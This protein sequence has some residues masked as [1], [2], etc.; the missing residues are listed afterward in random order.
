MRAPSAQ[1]NQA[2]TVVPPTSASCSSRLAKLGPLQDNG[3]ATQTHALLS[4]SPAIDAGDNTACPG[5]DQR[6]VV[7]PVDGNSDRVAICEIGAVEAA[8][9]TTVPTPAVTPD[10]TPAPTLGG[11]PAVLPRTGGPPSSPNATPPVVAAWAAAV[12]CLVGLWVIRKL[13]GRG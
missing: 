11:L 3:G 4:G 6:D 7:R 13:S 5:T 12:S 10:P 8:T 9:G 1:P 2:C